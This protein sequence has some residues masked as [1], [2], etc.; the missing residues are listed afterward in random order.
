MDEPRAS[1]KELVAHVFG[2]SGS[3]TPITYGEL[4]LR[5]GRLN[6]HGDGHGHGMGAVLGKM[7]HLLESVEDDWGATIPHIQSLVVNKTGTLRGLPDEGIKEFWVSYPNLTKQEK[8]KK[9]QAEYEKIRDFGSRWNKILSLLDIPQVEAAKSPS[10]KQKSSAYGKGGESELHLALKNYV[11]ANPQLVG[12]Q[13]DDEPFTEYVLPSLDTV[14]VLFKNSNRWTAVEVKS[15]ISDH[16][17]SDYERGLY[18]CV[19]YHAILEA[20]KTDNQ[21]QVPADIEVILVLESSLPPQ[22]RDLAEALQTKVVEKIT[23]NSS[24]SP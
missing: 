11:A 21:Y 23:P 7:G 15:R 24:P 18:Q 5:I 20:M 16:L 2:S 4:A 1:L 8:A 14:D 13:P 19:K 17:P 10:D 6:K 12:A 22:Y 3:L 9:A